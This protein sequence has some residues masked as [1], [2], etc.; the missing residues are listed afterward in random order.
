MNGNPD[1]Y[2]IIENFVER[3]RVCRRS[4][5]AYLMDELFRKYFI[6]LL[7]KTRKIYSLIL[8]LLL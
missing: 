8:G 2:A 4:N 6:T 1:I 7:Q 5:G 3:A